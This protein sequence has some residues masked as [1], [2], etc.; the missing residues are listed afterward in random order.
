MPRPQDKHVRRSKDPTRADYRPVRAADDMNHHGELELKTPIFTGRLAAANLIPAITVVGLLVAIGTIGFF[1][2]DSQVRGLAA[3]NTSTQLQTTAIQVLTTALT[4]YAVEAKG[5]R[6]RAL[7]EHE[8]IGRAFSDVAYIVSL[9][10]EKRER[11]GLEE[12]VGLRKRLRDG[13]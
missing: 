4:T 13:Q 9:S 7:K 8:A 5:D 3:L 2:W 1:I 11:L 6:E 12:P 10:Q